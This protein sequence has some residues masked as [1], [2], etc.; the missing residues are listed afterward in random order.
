MK[1]RSILH[2][3]LLLSIYLTGC[4]RV[5]ITQYNG[6]GEIKEIGKYFTSYG[7]NIELDTIDFS[8]P[9]QKEFKISNYPKIGKSLV[10]GISTQ[11]SEEN[12]HSLLVGE[13]LLQ[14]KNTRQETIFKCSENLSKW[15]FSKS[16]NSEKNL[17]EYFIYYAFINC[18]TWID[19]ETQIKNDP[20]YL[21][22]QYDPKSTKNKSIGA[23]QVKVGGHK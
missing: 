11:S 1:S 10:V 3:F 23:L 20:I 5:D 17:F 16:Y 6:E 9:T 2:L 21:T 14:A 18:K 4:Q 7:Y 19:P 15:R 8:I 22:I 12:L 13:L